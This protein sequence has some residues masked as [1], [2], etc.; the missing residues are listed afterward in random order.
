MKRHAGQGKTEG[1]KKT[2][3][4]NGFE[5]SPVSQFFSSDIWWLC[6]ALER[7]LVKKKKNKKKKKKKQGDEKQ[8]FLFS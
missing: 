6:F 3:S 8:T 5:Y 4:A 7:P 1:R 2:Q